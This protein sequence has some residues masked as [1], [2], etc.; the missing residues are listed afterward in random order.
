MPVT[1]EACSRV[2]GDERVTRDGSVP[3]GS[4]V[5][6]ALYEAV[7]AT[8]GRVHTDLDFRER[9][10]LARHIQHIRTWFRFHGPWLP[11]MPP[12]ISAAAA[13][14]VTRDC[15]AYCIELCDFFSKKSWADEIHM[16]ACAAHREL[17]REMIRLAGR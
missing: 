15:Y 17:N 3:E 13:P 14:L 16:P 10:G 7:D 11:S 4:V 2:L 5:D 8:L 6:D 1:C 12:R 9:V